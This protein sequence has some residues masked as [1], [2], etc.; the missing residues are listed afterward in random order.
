MV[1][2]GKEKVDR[3]TGKKLEGNGKLGLGGLPRI[4]NSETFE[5]TGVKSTFIISIVFYLD[6]R[7]EIWQ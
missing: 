7:K 1:P 3:G 6:I 5:R 4:M 2:L